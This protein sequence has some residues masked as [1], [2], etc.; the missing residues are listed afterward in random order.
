MHPPTLPGYEVLG[1]LGAGG[2]A[3]VW[4]ARR[5]VDDLE[6]ALKVV[7][8]GPGQVASALAEAGLLA[9]VRHPHVLHLYDVL[10]LLGADGR[11]EAVVLVTRLAGGGSLAQVLARRRLLS[12]GELVTV[13]HPVATTLADLHREGVVH[14][15]LS[16]GNLL[17][18]RD[19]MPLLADLGTARVVGEPGLRGL[20]TG[21]MDGMVAPEVLEGFP[22]ASASDVYQLGALAW[23]CLVG[24]PPGPGYDRRP[25]AEVAPE[26]S[27]V[28][29]ELVSRCLS[30][31]PED[32][33]DAQEVAGAVMEVAAP[34]PVEVAPDADAAHGVTRRL[35][36]VALEDASDLEPPTRGR[37]WRRGRGRP[38]GRT[39]HPP[40]RTGHPPGRAGL[41]RADPAMGGPRP[42][43]TLGVLGVTAAALL[44]M[45]LLVLWPR[46]GGP[47]TLVDRPV[48]AATTA[49]GTEPS[50]PTATAP[51]TTALPTTAPPTTPE[52]AAT[53]PPASALQ[54]L[55][56][57]RADAW[58][59]ADPSLLDAVVVPGSE[60]QAREQGA[61]E[62]VRDAEVSY[63]EVTFRVDAM[64]V[65][66]EEDDL[67]VVE[68]LLSRGAVR[69]Y[70]GEEVV[71]REPERQD[72]V[73]LE[74]VPTETGWL[75]SSWEP[76]AR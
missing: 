56:D 68:A 26:L 15:D 35:R 21:G 1:P 76:A 41:H 24:L 19:G 20:G 10:P 73:R 37:R 71:L 6:V 33:P 7:R 55:L 58:E 69:A 63:P 11:P 2:S 74:V 31:E 50:E 16:T 27:P 66:A 51:P 40:G 30:P 12:P 70:R 45:V 28:V 59:A 8:P 52:P 53:V 14:G 36:Q 17:F 32:R 62:Q 61:L 54:S 75:L 34:E 5:T 25:L 13:L 44:A 18:R 46:T 57:R 43:L 60:A 4:R 65:L 23:L 64:E 29:V 9:R 72:R 67:L 48:G 3:Q 49:T 39:G 22:A 38:P 47:T 42:A